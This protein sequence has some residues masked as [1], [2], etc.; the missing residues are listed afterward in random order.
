MRVR[1]IIPYDQPNVLIIPVINLW[2]TYIGFVD[3][4]NTPNGPLNFLFTLKSWHQITKDVL[5]VTVSLIGDG[6]AVWLRY[7]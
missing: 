1:L 4:I 5:Y 2:R 3:N 6:V 7:S